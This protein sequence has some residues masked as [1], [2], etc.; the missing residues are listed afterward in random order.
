MTN[1][2]CAGK[3]FAAMLALGAALALDP[4]SGAA[5][6]VD[7][8][9]GGPRLILL[10]DRSVPMVSCTVI[11][12]SGSA[13]ETPETNGAAHSLEHLLFNGTTARTREEIYALTDLLG[14]YNNA[15]TQRERTVFQ[16]LLP[17]EN[18]KDGIA[19]QS[20]MLLRSTLPPAMFEK[21]KGVILEELAKDRSDPGYD[22]QT[23]TESE[24]WGADPRAMPVL[25]TEST[26]RGMDLESIREFY[27]A[28]YR[29]ELMT[30]VLMGD[31]DSGEAG[32]VLA[33]AYAERANEA[34]AP[35]ARGEGATAARP[36]FPEGRTV[37]SRAMPALET[38]RVRV[39]L[40]MPSIDDP[41]AVDAILLADL[42]TEGR[43]ASVARA[44][45][46]ACGPVVE[47][48]AS[49]EGGA[50]WSL[51][52]IGADLPRDARGGEAP[53]SPAPAIGA[54]V[55]HFAA[56]AASNEWLA[57]MEDARV[58]RVVRET[59]LREKMHYFGLE[60]ADLL[61]AKEPSL[62]LELP[63]RIGACEPEN[64]RRLMASAATRFFVATAA[65]PALPDSRV[66]IDASDWPEVRPAPAASAPPAYRAIPDPPRTS[67]TGIRR[68]VR[69]DS[70]VLIVHESPEPRTFAIHAFLENR[71]EWEN[72]LGVPEGTADVL[73]RMMELGTADMARD[74]LRGA[75]GAIG[76]TLK[77]TDAD[78][79]PYDDYY[80]SPEFSYVRLET[81]D[82]FATEAI[83]VFGA[84][85]ARP[86]FDE[87][88]LA[89][90]A[91]AATARAR[92]DAQS[93]GA[94][95][96]RLFYGA[97][98]EGHP[99]ARA[100]DG[101]PGSAERVSLDDVR[102]LHA[103]LADPSNVILVVSSSLPAERIGALVREKLPHRPANETSAAAHAPAAAT[104]AAPFRPRP[105]AAR[106][107]TA[108]ETGR[109]QS[110]IV[111]GA[112]LE[113]PPEDQSAVRVAVALLS[114]RL[115]DQLREREG[116]AYSIGASAR[117]DEPGRCVTMSAGTR[118][119]NLVRMEA[120]MREIAQALATTPPTQEQIR[121][122]VNRMEGQL[123]MRRLT[124][125]GQ[126]FALGMAELRG[127]DP[128]QIDAEPAK[129]RAV[130]PQ[131]VER[132]A[133][134]TLAFDPSITA[135]AK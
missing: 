108:A 34:P 51:L 94:V 128:A 18:W 91:A 59:Q 88:T 21:E 125:I 65:G 83:D 134:R 45:E 80:F 26:I 90:A 31:F 60:R 75:L 89:T 127:R 2:S 29:P 71:A 13:F 1:V 97:L 115:A 67:R 3:G 129:L 111:V 19:L 116:L 39:M 110:A 49:F 79:V 109:E 78:G 98:G 76:A 46:A 14:A 53:G 112:P 12:P 122:A 16:L 54:I 27:R 30:I 119:E 57:D 23:F 69:P 84:I 135:I 73:H 4:R 15:S 37:V 36:P 117:L 9:P 102:R 38:T 123:R 61:G 85:L 92:K 130:T 93:P 20:D 118:P 133:R 42:L 35:G 55:A 120:G 58:S 50:P 48:W 103:R 96:E 6:P 43:H 52:T 131:D 47:C 81:I 25:G 7:S 8:I 74:D 40:P 99:R 63:S 124:R 62:A 87:S 100:V 64:V 10:P 82:A 22:A 11:V 101:A 33:A 104:A 72:A 70:L 66:R 113:V 41:R 56:L 77:V 106:V 126:A 107:E 68:I 44:I 114:E 86:R 5:S 95:A 105:L 28:R 24:T 132:V 121:G 17:S 32:E